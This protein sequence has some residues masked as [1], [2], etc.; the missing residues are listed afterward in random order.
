MK[1]K[2]RTV[3]ISALIAVLLIATVFLFACNS[4]VSEGDYEYGVYIRR[5]LY[6]PDAQEMTV[7]VSVT[8]DTTKTIE[9]ATGNWHYK[10]ST[11]NAFYSRYDYTVSFSPKTI[12][13]AVKDS[14]TQEQLNVDGVEYNVLK[15]VFE[16][17]TIYKSLSSDGERLKIG[18][19]YLHDFA[20]DE[21]NEEFATTLS[22]RVQNSA[23]WYGVLVAVAV[24]V[25]GAI[26]GTLLARRKKYATKERTENN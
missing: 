9:G 23:T 3:Y 12:F 8:S 11:E 1:T 17:A 22:L 7:Y 5:T 21:T 6:N 4:G 19:T 20:L 10:K 14:L 25:F 15:L 2:R 13:S 26:I 18:S 24:A 16:Y